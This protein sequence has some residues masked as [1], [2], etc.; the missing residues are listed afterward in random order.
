MDKNSDK[1]LPPEMRPL[2]T[3]REIIVA[4]AMVS[5][6]ALL[7]FLV[8]PEALANGEDVTIK[9]GVFRPL[10]DLGSGGIP[11]VIGRIIRAIISLSGVLA[12][13]MFVYGGV[14]WMTAQGNSEKVEQARRTVVWSVLGLVLIFASYAM[15]GLVLRALGQ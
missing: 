14:T 3:A 7:V 11:V 8:G 4:T 6:A 5:G 2:V 15:V 10:G 1:K 9:S 13:A 12:L